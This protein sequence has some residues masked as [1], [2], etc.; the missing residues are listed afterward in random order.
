MKLFFLIL[1]ISCGQSD[2]QIKAPEEDVISGETYSYVIFQ[3]EF[4]QQIK[5]LCQELYLPQNFE[6]TELYKQ[7]VAEC[8]FDNLSILDLG[9]IDEFTNSICGNPQTQE[10][11]DTCTALN[12]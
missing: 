12:I 8:S 3:L 1:L 6:S 9:A 11:I 10:E 5:T 4:I 7:K 2:I